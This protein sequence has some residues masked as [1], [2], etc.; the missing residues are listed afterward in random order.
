MTASADVLDLVRDELAQ[1]ETVLLRQSAS[2]I[3]PVRQVAQHLQAGGGKRLRPALHLLAARF[4]G[5]QG[6]AAIHIGAVLELIHTATL[7]HDDIIDAADVRRGR[8]S[9]NQQWGNS[10][11]VLAGDWLYMES[12]RLALA[13][14]NFRVL[15]VLIELTQVMVE[16]ELIQLTQLGRADITESEALEITRR[17]TSCLFRACTQLGAL[18]GGMSP[19]DEER[20]AAYGLNLGMAFQII[21]DLLD[22]TAAPERLGKPVLNDL[23]EGKVTLPLVYALQ[24]AAAGERAQVQTVLRERGFHSVAPEQIVGIV[25]RHDGIE[26]TRARAQEYIAEARRSLDSFPDSPYKQALLAIPQ[27]V[28]E[29]DH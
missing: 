17:K 25:I 23:R 18:L 5:Y 1:V 12:F 21:D 8:P 6:S 15:D 11:T 10:M 19:A 22:F 27:F 9:A 7:V 24:S 20:L 28:L 13:E 4:C 14:R 2:A 3:E 29:R 26:R 16:G